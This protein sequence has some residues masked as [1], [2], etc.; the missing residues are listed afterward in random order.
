MEAVP[1]SK[2][3]EYGKP[4]LLPGFSFLEIRRS[5]ISERIDRSGPLP[6][7]RYQP[8]EDVPGL[9]QGVTVKDGGGCGV[10]FE[11]LEDALPAL[12]FDKPVRLH[13]VHGATVL[14][15]DDPAFGPEGEG[16]YPD[17]DGVLGFRPG[18][19]AVVSAADCV[20]V[21]LLGR[22]AR[23]WAAVH[24]GWRGVVAGVLA[25]AVS[26]MEVRH[27]VRPGELE[28]YLG[29]SICGKCYRV[30]EDVAVTLAEAGDGSGIAMIGD[31][32]FADL[33]TILTHQARKLGVRAGA[34]AVS[35]YCTSCHNEFFCSFRSEGEQG[36]RKMWG[37]IGLVRRG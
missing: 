13:Q 24:A 1:V 37:I 4:G 7:L 27:G 31:D 3:E 30:G 36:L 28:L 21:F 10:R 16:M 25:S 6:L 15:H 12:G 34:V 8:W 29:P 14:D 32:H 23:V 17:G 35:S 33:R 22:N 5:I 2:I 9:V 19:L 11:R 18:L 20:P 26:M